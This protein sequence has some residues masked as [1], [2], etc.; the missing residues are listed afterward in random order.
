MTD[1]R[2]PDY[3]RYQHLIVDVVD[4]IA[5]IT[6]N[7][8]ERLNAINDQLHRELRDVWIDMGRDD[9][10]D[11]IILTGSGR[12]FCAGGDVKDLHSVDEPFGGGRKKEP[13]AVMAA[14]ARR[15]ANEML[16]VEQPIIAAVNGD[17]FGLGANIALL[18]DIVIMADDARI[19]DTHVN[20]GLVA[21][22]GGAVI[23][24]ILIG[25]HRAKEFLMR[26]TRLT[27]AE[28]AAMG[29]INRAVPRAEVLA[30]AQELATELA[31]GA[32]LAIRWTKYSV[33]KALK[34]AM[35]LVFDVSIAFELTSMK[36]A[37]HREG[38]AA[39]NEKRKPKFTG[40]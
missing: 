6:M 40:R 37:D 11:A 39:F 36:S 27:G 34:H 16:D 9:R 30:Q 5:T 26:G 13:L 28:A 22:D 15:L 17:A 8:P 35:N 18:C 25:P 32:P 2:T 3:S 29:L 20:V 19:A 38:I 21:G 14:D 4:N 33:N 10:V 23:W 12:A 24:P 1:D 31:A 7:R